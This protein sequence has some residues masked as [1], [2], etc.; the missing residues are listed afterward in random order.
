MFLVNGYNI[1]KDTSSVG[2]DGGWW[3]PLLTGRPNTMPP[4]YALL[5][6]KPVTPGYSQSIPELVLLLEEY[7]PDSPKGV[8]ALCEWGEL[9]TSTLVKTRCR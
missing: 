3:I 6:E 8:K 9:T 1:Y 4:Q 7:Q 2:S 5:N